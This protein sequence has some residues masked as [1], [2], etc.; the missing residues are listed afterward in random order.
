MKTPRL[1]AAAALTLGALMTLTACGKSKPVT[2]D[3]APAPA[4]KPAPLTIGYSD[5]PGWVAWEV[6]G[7]KKWFD[8]QGGRRREVRVVRLRRL[9][10]RLAAA[11]WTAW[12]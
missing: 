5:W 6:G 10:G 2:A 4:G 11:T 8:R 1:L 9:H 7:R 12:A 3:A